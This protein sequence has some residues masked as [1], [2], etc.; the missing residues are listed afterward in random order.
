MK[1]FNLLPEKS[2]QIPSQLCLSFLLISGISGFGQSN[3]VSAGG[4]AEGSNGSVS[5]SIGQIFYISAEGENGNIN[6]GVQQPYDAEIITGIEHEQIRAIIYPNPTLGQ[7][8]LQFDTDSYSN[9]KA[10]LIDGAGK[11]VG[12]QTNL[13]SNNIFSLEMAPNG[14]YTLTVYRNEKLIK[15]FRIVKNN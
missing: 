6:Q 13:S 14:I 4:D 11:L 5:Y 9:C 15:S 3:T 7:I 8:Q 1:Q 2:K 12:V 10:E